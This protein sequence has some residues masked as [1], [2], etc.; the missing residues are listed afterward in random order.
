MVMAREGSSD[1]EVELEE[2]SEYVASMAMIKKKEQVIRHGD[3]KV[4]KEDLELQKG[5]VINA[6]KLS[7]VNLCVFFEVE[8]V[9][10]SEK[11][12]MISLHIKATMMKVSDPIIFG[13][14]VK[15]HFKDVYAKHGDMLAQPTI[16]IKNG[17]GDLYKKI[18]GHPKE[19]KI[20]A[21]IEAVYTS[22]PWLALV[23]S[24]KGITNLHVPGDAII[25]ASMPKVVRKVGQMCNKADMLEEVKEMQER[26]HRRVGHPAGRENWARKRGGDELEQPLPPRP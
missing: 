21:N 8:M 2:D 19:A 3:T 24:A 7:A 14:C 4:L 1:S 10:C 25:E 6:T 26:G 9:D 5:K 16:N 20:L 23:N 22:R 15:V 11:K 13:H 17:L 12:L 18:A